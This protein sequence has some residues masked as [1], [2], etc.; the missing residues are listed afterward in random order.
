MIIK[1]S[2]ELIDHYIFQSNAFYVIIIDGSVLKERQM[3]RVLSIYD[4]EDI[5]LLVILY[6][7]MYSVLY[8]HL[9]KFSW[10]FTTC[11]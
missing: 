8:T 5:D 10:I 11:H 2:Q 1:L 4:S 7:F 9:L 6:V 3:N